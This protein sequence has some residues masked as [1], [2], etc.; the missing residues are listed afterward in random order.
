[1]SL[2][3]PSTHSPFYDKP[4]QVAMM[5]DY[6]EENPYQELLSCSI[7]QDLAK[8]HFP[9]G[10][11]R[12]LPLIRGTDSLGIPVDVLHL[13][14]IEKYIVDRKLHPKPW[15]YLRLSMELDLL[16]LKGVALVWTIHN[17]I[18]H[19]SKSMALQLACNR[20]VAR[21]ARR[22]I[23]HSHSALEAVAP[24]YRLNL[25]RT[26]VIPHGNYRSSYP[27]ATPFAQARERLGLHSGE[28]V[29]LFLGMLRPYKGLED[30]ITAWLSLEPAVRRNSRLLIAGK[31]MEE[32][33]SEQLRVLIN[34]APD[35]TL[36][37]R[38]VPDAVMGD[39][40]G[41]ADVSILPFKRILTSGSLLLAMSY[42][43]PVIVPDIPYTRELLPAE[44][45]GLM[46]S[47]EN[48]IA[49][50]ADSIRRSVDSD[51]HQLGAAVNRRANDFDWSAIGRQHA[52]LYQAA[53]KHP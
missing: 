48:P 12:L 33:Y 7:P 24:I 47:L 36:H 9:M 46:Y 10:Y 53:S 28:R 50:L 49:G 15:Y 39:Y 4:L 34:N 23:L 27:A 44:L 31:A 29:F 3:Q 40:F 35:I 21:K 22:V 2:S 26:V 14:W 51:L 16:R 20:L 17:M 8:V 13:H 45:S 37:D 41:A 18:S 32:S 43:L 42:G 19:S 5:P 30:L 11:K 25:R 1:M 6:R 52:E 38:F